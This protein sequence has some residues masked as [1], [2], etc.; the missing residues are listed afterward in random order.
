VRNKSL[1]LATLLVAAAPWAGAQQVWRCGNS[2]SQQPCPGATAVAVDD[3]RSPSELAAGARTAQDDLKRAEALQKMRLE[4]ERSAP[5]A[6]VIASP[7]ERAA[8]APQ[9]SATKKAGR[10]DVFTA[11]TPRHPGEK[12]KA[13]KKHKRKTAA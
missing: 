3:K 2:Y 13:K 8:S 5:K 1:F 4:A 11:S 6:V 12:A 10:P 9:R 7:P